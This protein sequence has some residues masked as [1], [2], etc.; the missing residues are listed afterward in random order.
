MLADDIHSTLNRI[1]LL[2]KRPLFF[3]VGVPRSGTTWL[4]QC[5]DNHPEICC[6]GESHF[7]DILFRNLQKC[8]QSYNRSVRQQGGTVAHLRQFGGH[9]NTLRYDTNDA[10]FLL[11]L[12]MYLI[13]DKWVDN[14]EIRIIGEKTPDNIRAITLLSSIFP[15][16]RFVHIVRDGRDAAVS[17]WFFNKSGMDR[18]KSV[19]QSF[20]NYIT[21]FIR[22]WKTEI[23]LARTVGASLGNK[24]HEISFES[25]VNEPLEPL[26]GVLE[27]LG[28]RSETTL[29]EHCLHEARFEMHSGGRPA[30]TEDRSSF[31]RKG[32]AGDWRGHLSET[33]A[34]RAWD[35]AGDVLAASGY[36]RQ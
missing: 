13:F 19:A 25:M 26:R 32:I 14:P 7:T 5:L 6:L 15:D 23:S 31:Y 34:A 18:N 35:V 11:F 8:F 1:E 3:I 2:A 36:S 20:D 12:S 9:V 29:V 28:A 30:G 27:F 4:Q 16:S 22:Q 10:H 24:Y 33:L 21:G 17:G